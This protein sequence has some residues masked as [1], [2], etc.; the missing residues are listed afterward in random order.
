MYQSSTQWGDQG[1]YYVGFSCMATHVPGGLVGFLLNTKAPR[2]WAWDEIC[3]FKHSAWRKFSLR[4]ACVSSQ[5]HI[6]R[7]NLVSVLNGPETQLCLNIRIVHWAAL[8]R[9]IPGGAIY[10]T[11]VAATRYGLWS[12]LWKYDAFWYWSTFATL[13][14][15][16]CC[17]PIMYWPWRWS[18]FLL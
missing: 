14:A 6:C 13:P 10:K 4:S 3:G 1:P 12:W 2:S 9:W 18:K 15:I 11:I 16:N 7:K 5:S 17:Q 8:R